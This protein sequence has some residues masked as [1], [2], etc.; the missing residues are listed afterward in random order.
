MRLDKSDKLKDMP[1]KLVPEENIQRLEVQ[2]AVSDSSAR[3]DSDDEAGVHRV[4]E[5]LCL[6][7]PGHL[8]KTYSRKK[9]PTNH[10]FGEHVCRN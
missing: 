10:D 9:R 5:T 7:S 6:L 1:G 2:S 3:Y 8:Q 4:W